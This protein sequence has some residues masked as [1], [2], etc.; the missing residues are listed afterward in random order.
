MSPL[1]R[2]KA[3]IGKYRTTA[4]TSDEPAG[5]YQFALS[6][7]S[8]VKRFAE[9]SFFKRHQ[10]SMAGLKGFK[11]EIGG[12]GRPLAA[13]ENYGGGFIPLRGLRFSMESLAWLGAGHSCVLVLQKSSI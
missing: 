2:L 10:G 1:R 9:Y 13:L 11:D 6:A 7:D 5:F 4:P 12:Y 8:V 3:A